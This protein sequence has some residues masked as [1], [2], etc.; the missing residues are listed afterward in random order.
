MQ[1]KIDQELI[2]GDFH[3]TI[4]EVPSTEVENAEF[5]LA[6]KKYGIPQIDVGGSFTNGTD[7][8]ELFKFNSNIKQI[9]NDLPFSK[10][11]K[12]SQYGVNAKSHAEAYSKEVGKRIT[13]A[14]DVLRSG[15]D[16]FSNADIDILF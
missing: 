12:T 16:D 3:V 4:F 5:I 6:T 15:A 1:I 7:P 11:F 13:D 8:T 2:N 10:V 14:L 9:P